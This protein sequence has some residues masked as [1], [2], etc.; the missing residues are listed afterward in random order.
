[1]VYKLQKKL[2]WKWKLIQNFL[3][4]VNIKEKKH[5]DEISNDNSSI[6]SQSEQE[7]FSVNYFIYIVDQAITS[8]T[9][10]FEQY[11]Q[12]DNIFGF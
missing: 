5:F 8:L 9:T 1:M 12:Y 3:K 11:Q 7:S 6:V 10:R 4:G 2:L